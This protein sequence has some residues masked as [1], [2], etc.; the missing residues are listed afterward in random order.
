[1]L[2]LLCKEAVDCTAFRYEPA[3]MRVFDLMPG[4]RAKKQGLVYTVSITG[5]GA[6][7]D[8]TSYSVAPISFGSVDGEFE[9]T[10]IVLNASEIPQRNPKLLPKLAKRKTGWLAI[11]GISDAS[12][13]SYFLNLSNG[14]AGGSKYMPYRIK[15][16]VVQTQKPSNAAKLLAKILSGSK[17]G[18]ATK[19]GELVAPSDDFAKGQAKLSAQAAVYDAQV[20]L[21]AAE[22]A[23]PRVEEAVKSAELKL[24][25]AE[26]ARANL[27]D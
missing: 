24:E 9:V 7:P 13:R 21:Q 11:P 8:G 3:Y 26:N 15:A 12:K 14:T 27:Q 2:E 4:N 19:V 5:P 23:V 22:D 20:A 10:D 1:M 18:L 16:D 6:A 17:D 25:I